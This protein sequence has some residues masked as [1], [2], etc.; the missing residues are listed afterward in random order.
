MQNTSDDLL[1]DTEGATIKSLE[2]SE[3]FEAEAPSIELKGEDTGEMGILRR[4]Q[5]HPN[6]VALEGKTEEEIL[7]I[8]SEELVK[9]LWKQCETIGW[10][11]DENKKPYEIHKQEDGSYLL[12]SYLHKGSK[13]NAKLVSELKHL[14]IIGIN[15]Q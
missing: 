14:G 10:W 9:Q 8:I 13:P 12:I 7:S 4:I 1:P 11:P 2:S 5:F 6:Y 3:H 15:E